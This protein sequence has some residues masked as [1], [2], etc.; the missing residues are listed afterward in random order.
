MALKCLG[1]FHCKPSKPGTGEQAPKRAPIYMTVHTIRLR[2]GS[3]GTDADIQED[4]ISHINKSGVLTKNWG[5][6]EPITPHLFAG[7]TWFSVGMQGV[8]ILRHLESN[9]LVAGE[10]RL[11]AVL[12]SR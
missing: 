4:G 1:R 6:P 12:A 7:L 8:A 5:T 3:D 11:M 2:C 9:N 10:R